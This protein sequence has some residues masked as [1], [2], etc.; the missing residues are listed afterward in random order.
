M[1]LKNFVSATLRE[2]IEGVAEARAVVKNIDPNAAINPMLGS[3]T[4]ATYTPI[5]NV[6]FDVAVTATSATGTK[7]GIGI[8]VGPVALGS[9]GKSDRSNQLASRIKFVV[10]ITLPQDTPRPPSPQKKVHP[11]DRRHDPMMG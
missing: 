4:G 2:I 5:Q 8:M 3:G 7:G 1:E 6:E 11:M 10:P 9:Q